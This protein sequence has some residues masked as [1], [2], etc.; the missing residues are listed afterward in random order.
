VL[1]ITIKANVPAADVVPVVRCK[2]CKYY[3]DGRRCEVV[4]CWI[5]TRAAQ[6]EGH[7]FTD[8]V[9]Y[10]FCWTKK[11]AIKRFG[12]LYDDV[13]PFEVDKVVF[14]PFRRLPV[15]VTDY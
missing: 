11:Q 7:E 4:F 2:D 10:C 3:K 14:D 8:D 5:F 1:T 12:Q 6:M 15:V 9:A 13:K